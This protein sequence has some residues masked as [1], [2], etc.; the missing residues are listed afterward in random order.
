PVAPGDTGDAASVTPPSPREA[1]EPANDEVDPEV[2]ATFSKEELTPQDYTDTPT[3]AQ[4]PPNKARNIAVPAGPEAED[5]YLSVPRTVLLLPRLTLDALFFPIRGLATLVDKYHLVEQ[6]EDILYNDA[7]TAAIIPTLGYQTEYGFT[8]GAKVFHNDV[9]GNDEE[10]SLSA[11]YGG[12]YQQAYKFSFEGDEVLHTPLWVEVDL[13]YEFKPGVLFWG[14]GN[15]P[16]SEAGPEPV[17]PRTA[18]IESRYRENRTLASLL[19]GETIRQKSRWVQV[20]MMGIYNRRR[21][22]PSEG[23]FNEPSLE[24]AYDT[25]EIV[26]YEEGVD[27]LEVGPVLEFDSRDHGVLTSDGNYL[28][29]FASYGMPFQQDEGFWHYGV[30]AATFINLYKRTRVLSFRAVLETIHGDDDE[31]PFTELMR[32][33]GS[34]RL[35]GYG[36]DRFRDNVSFVA[37]AEYRY[38]IHD[39]VA[40]EVFVDAGRVGAGYG[41]VFA[42]SNDNPIRAGAG[43]GLVVHNQ[44]DVL[45]K[46]EAAYGD[47]LTLF[48]AT[49][50]LELFSERHKRL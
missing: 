44:E 23:S 11:E 30:T 38:P 8:G 27:V 15:E 3:G 6:V 37:T 2:E 14:I 21:F 12:L 4:P 49:S 10:V 47:E 32:L 19:V 45:F 25:S 26:G 20:G 5:V 22:G 9:L 7:R 41:D 13:R 24:E 33:G 16:L 42:F 40:G 50:P 46:A 17:D 36:S 29:S 43:L 48:L 31:I 1:S 18:A 34:D 35:R 39:S 28:N